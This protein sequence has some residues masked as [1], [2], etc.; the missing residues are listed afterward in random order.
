ME[1]KFNPSILKTK[2]LYKLKKNQE[3]VKI[4][5]KKSYF[6][7]L[8]FKNYLYFMKNHLISA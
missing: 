5:R 4:E 2:F 7:I 3:I 8:I 6:F 1:K